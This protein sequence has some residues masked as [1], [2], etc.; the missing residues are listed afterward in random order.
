M[1][2]I[3]NIYLFSLVNPSLASSILWEPILAEHRK[4]VLLHLDTTEWPAE[5]GS[6]F[7]GAHSNKNRHDNSHLVIRHTDRKTVLPQ[8]ARA[9][10]RLILEPE[11][12]HRTYCT[13]WRPGPVLPIAWIMMLYPEPEPI[14]LGSTLQ[15]ILR[16]WC[17]GVTLLHAHILANIKGQLKATYFVLSESTRQRY[18][19]R[20]GKWG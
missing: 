9:L 20:W 16:G 8:W 7:G 3:T 13:E 19:C 1:H 5:V 11:T 4:D 10:S 6:G 2:M 15:A 14:S 12:P 18:I 17:L